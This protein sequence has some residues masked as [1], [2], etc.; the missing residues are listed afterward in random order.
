M[1]KN[2]YRLYFP[3]PSPVPL[4][5]VSLNLQRPSVASRNCT[6]FRVRLAVTTHSN[7]LSQSEFKRAVISLIFCV[8]RTCL[9]YINPER[10]QFDASDKDLSTLLLF[11]PTHCPTLIVRPS[12]SDPHYL[13]CTSNLTR[14]MLLSLV[15]AH[16]F[17]DPI[18]APARKLSTESLH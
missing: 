18:F 8:G 11:D 4:L 12:L 5:H 7:N 2:S 15:Q 10:S 13:S 9:L 17:S 6:A 1:K 14:T 3:S 16:T